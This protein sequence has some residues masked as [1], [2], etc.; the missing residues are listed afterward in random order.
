MNLFNE[1]S[2]IGN[3]SIDIVIIE[4]VKVQQLLFLYCGQEEIQ[5]D[6]SIQYISRSNDLDT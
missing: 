5:N 2:I 6:Y 4:E 3:T 1:I